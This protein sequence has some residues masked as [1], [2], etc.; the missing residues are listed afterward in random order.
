[1]DF[2]TPAKDGTELADWKHE[3][4]TT[5]FAKTRVLLG[6]GD[7]LEPI[8][9]LQF[10]E[11]GQLKRETEKLASVLEFGTAGGMMQTKMT[12]ADKTLGQ[13][14]R[15]KTMDKLCSRQGHLFLFA[16]VAI[17]EILES[18]GIVGKR[19]D[20][21]I[22]NG[23]AKDVAT[24]ILH[25]CLDATQW[26]LDVDFPI[27]GKRLGDHLLDIESPVVGIQFA[28]CPELGDGETKAVAELI[29]KQLDGE[30][31]LVGSSLPAIARAGR[32]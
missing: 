32:T 23:N 29:G 2:E 15:E 13:D 11:E 30:E 4:Q 18:D 7:F 6:Q 28:G 24:E 21:M 25:Q 26:R 14:M 1:M 16:L 5:E 8:E 31:E 20:T 3:A 22:G 12:N 27:F 9:E 19:K 17:V 10:G